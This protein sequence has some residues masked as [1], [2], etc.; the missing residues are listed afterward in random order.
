MIGAIDTLRGWRKICG[1]KIMKT[2]THGKV[3]RQ[4]LCRN[5][6]LHELCSKPPFE[7]TDEDILDL[8]KLI[9]EE[10]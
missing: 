10:L 9:E 7:L 1:S 3:K 4:P 6:K 5:C 2:Q 8:V